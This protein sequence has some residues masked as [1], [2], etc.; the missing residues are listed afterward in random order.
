MTNVGQGEI[1]QDAGG[2]LAKLKKASMALKVERSFI[3]T[4]VCMDYFSHFRRVT[5][6]P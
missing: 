3:P 6:V 1:L 2:E 4:G 5:P